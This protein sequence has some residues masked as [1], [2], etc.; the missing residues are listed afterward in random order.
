MRSDWRVRLPMRNMALSSG[1]HPMT[2]ACA[3]P[4]PI[5]YLYPLGPRPLAHAAGPAELDAGGIFDGLLAMRRTGETLFETAERLLLTTALRRRQWVQTGAALLL[6]VSNRV[7]TDMCADGWAFPHNE[8]PDGVAWKRRPA[9][10]AK[11][12]ERHAS[13]LIDG[14]GRWARKQ[15]GPGAPASMPETVTRPQVDQQPLAA[16]GHVL[17]RSA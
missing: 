15:S 2:C 9:R 13:P 11:R 12:R 1:V 6:G 3:R 7:V 10:A 4:L 8:I 17:E 5:S 16:S 14:R